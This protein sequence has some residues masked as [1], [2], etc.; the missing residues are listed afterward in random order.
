MFQKVQIFVFVIHI[1]IALCEL[2]LTVIVK[3][4]FGPG[5]CSLKNIHMQQLLQ[6]LSE[7]H[8]IGHICKNQ[9]PLKRVLL[10]K[11]N[12]RDICRFYLGHPADPPLF[13]KNWV[14]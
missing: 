4:I 11:T 2:V 8:E 9:I 7:F 6:K 13:I 10:R 1:I 14:R 3:R 12:N 5:K